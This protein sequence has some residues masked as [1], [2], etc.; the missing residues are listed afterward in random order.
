MALFLASWVGIATYVGVYFLNKFVARRRAMQQQ[1]TQQNSRN[2]SNSDLSLSPVR[3]N[4]EELPPPPSY[5]VYEQKTDQ[6]HPPAY[7]AVT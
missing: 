3:L 6:E 1:L 4:V 5:A 7:N 2:L